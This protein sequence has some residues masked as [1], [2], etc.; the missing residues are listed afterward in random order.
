MCYCVI[1]EAHKALERFDASVLEGE[2]TITDIANDLDRR[3]VIIFLRPATF[4]S[5]SVLARF[6][7]TKHGVT[8]FAFIEAHVPHAV[9]ISRPRQMCQARNQSLDG[10]GKIWRPSPSRLLDRAFLRFQYSCWKY[11]VTHR[12][13]S[14][15]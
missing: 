9:K 4:S 12:E 3:S 15:S 2:L 7:A 6:D 8:N 10:T 11:A 5:R 1:L 14:L 13:Q